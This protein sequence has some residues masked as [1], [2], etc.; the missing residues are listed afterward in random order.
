MLQ[1]RRLLAGIPQL[2]GALVRLEKSHQCH[3][4]SKVCG[5]PAR[6]TSPAQLSL[7][8]S[9][10]EPRTSQDLFAGEQEGTNLMRLR[11]K[12]QPEEAEGGGRGGLGKV[13][14]VTGDEE[15]LEQT[16]PGWVGDLR[17]RRATDGGGKLPPASARVARVRG[18]AGST[19]P[20]GTPGVS[21]VSFPSPGC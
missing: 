13:G 10:A 17:S 18:G 3:R 19:P 1:P 5:F 9:L 20:P 21:G 8:K 7:Q 16:R 11:W 14:G 2:L 4:E 12:R 15:S 6:E